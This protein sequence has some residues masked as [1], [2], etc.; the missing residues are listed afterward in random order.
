M[1]VVTATMGYN[2]QEMDHE[3]AREEICA[4]T[5]MLKMLPGYDG[6][7]RICELVRMQITEITILGAWSGPA[8]LQLFEH[9]SGLSNSNKPNIDQ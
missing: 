6:K 3:Q 5:F 7:L 1:G 8:R 4:P 2:H 9:A